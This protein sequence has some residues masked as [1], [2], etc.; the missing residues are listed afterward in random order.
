MM[1][2]RQP[3]NFVITGDSIDTK[4]RCRRGN[5]PKPVTDIL[6]AWFHEHVDHPYPDEEDKRMFIIQTGLSISQVCDEY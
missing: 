3:A 1:A 6:R 5:L 2:R 4:M